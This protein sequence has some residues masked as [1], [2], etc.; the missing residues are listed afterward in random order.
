MGFHYG[1]HFSVLHVKVE[2][3][4]QNELNK[5]ITPD[6]DEEQP[7]KRLLDLIRPRCETV[8]VERGYIDFDYRAGF[9]RFY[10]LRHHDTSR[11]CTRLHFFACQLTKRQLLKMPRRVKEEYLGFVVIR[12]LPGFRIGRS[13]LSSRLVSILPI[14]EETYITC[15]VKYRVNLAGNEIEFGGVPWME[16]DTLVSACASAALWVACTHMANKLAPELKGYCTPHITDLATRYSVTT[17]RPMP[18]EG[19]TIEQMMYA[20]QEMGYEPVPYVPISASEAHNISYRY[21]ES[22]IPVVIILAFPQ[23]GHA[24]TAIGHTQDLSGNPKCNDFNIGG[25]VR[26]SICRTSDFSKRFVI[27]DDAGGPFRYLEF[28]DWEA[29]IKNG[30]LNKKSTLQLK[31]KYGCAVMLDEGTPAEQIGYLQALIVPLPP[32][33]TLD[34]YGAEIRAIALSALL[35]EATGTTSPPV[36]V[37]RTFLQTSN[38]AKARLEQATGVS[39]TLI[40]ELRRHP[41]SKWVWVTEVADLHELQT[42]HN[43]LG[44]FFQDSASHATC[45]DFFDLIAF[46]MPNI[47]VT[48]PSSGDESSIFPIP[49][50][51]RI[52]RFTR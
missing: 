47:L 8:I 36:V 20:L 23:G 32:G 38:K 48:V 6:G 27:Q 19:L 45:A 52:Q 51:T 4:D 7:A 24:V 1:E 18:S 34:G 42:S 31:Q 13:I 44:Q 26:L 2:P 46:H 50:N 40:R 22:E 10:Y 11:R 30:W 37:Y 15:Q 49:P 28:I 5:L 29:A 39:I 41:M 9:S 43:I 25:Q 16:Q 21:V 35:F 3:D 12:P 14:P 33:I 17:G